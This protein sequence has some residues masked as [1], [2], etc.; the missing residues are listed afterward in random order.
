MRLSQFHGAVVNETAFLA[1]REQGPSILVDED[2]RE[3]LPLG[4]MS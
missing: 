4:I 3:S 2:G 1:P